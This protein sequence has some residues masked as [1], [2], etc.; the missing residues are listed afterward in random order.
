MDYYKKY[1]K[2]KN[3]YLQLKIGGFFVPEHLFSLYEQIIPILEKVKLFDSEYNDVSEL[4]ETL[5][6]SALAITTDGL[7]QI[8]IELSNIIHSSKN[9][10][11][12][13]IMETQ[14]HILI[15]L[16]TMEV[17]DY[18]FDQIISSFSGEGINHITVLDGINKINIELKNYDQLMAILR[19]RNNQE[20][21]ENM[22]RIIRCCEEFINASLKFVDIYT[23]ITRFADESFHGI[24]ERK[25][26]T[27]KVNDFIRNI[28]TENRG[29]YLSI[30][31]YLKYLFDYYCIKNYISD[32]DLSII[33][34]IMQLLRAVI[35]EGC[36]DF[37]EIIK[38]YSYAVSNKENEYDSNILENI[39]IRL[40]EKLIEAER[41]FQ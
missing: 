4:T 25:D 39:V 20:S 15:V 37:N 34:H 7:K 11:T 30:K 29:Y 5:Y 23:E 33:C 24:G 10:F 22:R 6:D 12:K 32:D 40:Q 19:N 41:V 18:N 36:F 17:F 9:I 3:K 35:Y 8:T 2:Y 28:I 38:Q 16:H 31:R 1:L 13:I 21:E 14:F 26:I 27:V